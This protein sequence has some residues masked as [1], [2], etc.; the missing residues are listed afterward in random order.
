M[1]RAR[2]ALYVSPSQLQAFASCERRWYYESA[3]EVPRPADAGG[4]YLALGQLVDYLADSYASAGRT[5]FVPAEVVA[6]VRANPRNTNVGA[7]LTE[8]QWAELVDRAL[9]AFRVLQPLLVRGATQHRY[10]VQLAPGLFLTGRADIRA[11]DGGLILDVK[12]TVDRK[13][14]VGRDKDTPA[15]A[16][17][18]QTLGDDWQARCYAWAEF[19]ANPHRLSVEVRWLYVSKTAA[20]SAWAVSRVF[21][22]AETLAWFEANVRPVLERMLE[23]AGSAGLDPESAKANHD[24]CGRCFM[25]HVCHPFNGAQQHTRESTGTNMVDLSR[26][27]ARGR[28]AANPAA[29]ALLEAQAAQAAVSVP[30]MALTPPEPAAAAIGDDYA[31]N[32]GVV[33][34]PREDVF[35][36]A[37]INR[38]APPAREDVYAELVAE[39][40]EVAG[41]PAVLADRRADVM[42]TDALKVTGVDHTTGTLTVSALE[43][44]EVVPETGPGVGAFEGTLV[45]PALRR[46]RGTR[47]RKPRAVVPEPSADVARTEALATAVQQFA[48]AA[49]TLVSALNAELRR[50]G[51]GVGS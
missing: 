44:V 40:A 3:A 16:K 31:A 14:G 8:A 9:R 38:P 26:L 34:R 23:L 20:S 47:P 41:G 4:Q 45:E 17:T 39:A 46:G 13:P 43:V 11:N 37:A 29:L 25:K 24:S 21:Q 10:R 22:R 42:V 27:R 5:S 1:A 48:D 6:A 28:P 30:P 32:G 35:S 2:P 50:L 15:Y 51:V 33:L 18:S 49:N 19:Q 7:A 36:A 12:T